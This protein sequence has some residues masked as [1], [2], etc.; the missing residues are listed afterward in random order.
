[1]GRLLDWD[2]AV[3]E[4]AAL[5][6]DGRRL[7]FTNG[8][9]DLLHRGHVELLEKARALGD[10]LFVGVNSDDSA[11]RLKGAGRPLVPE[12][13]RAHVLC[14]LAAVDAVVLFAEDT[15]ARLIA[16][17]E[18]DVLV[19]GADYGP[20]EIVGADTVEARGGLVVRIPLVEGR[21]T[22]GLVE[23]IAR[24]AAQEA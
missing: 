2:A 4:R 22:S 20:G 8:V 3:A 6:R 14:A 11:R 19:K 5:A 9:F 23:R 1:M 12:D 16:A 18:P 24:R 21:S 7:V 15:P 17:L 13:D 10:A